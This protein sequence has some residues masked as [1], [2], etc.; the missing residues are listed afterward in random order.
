MFSEYLLQFPWKDTT[1]RIYSKTDEDVRR[2][3]LKRH[4]QWEDFLALIS[5]AADPYL[6]TMARKSRKITEE[7]FGRI[8]NLFLPL[9]L[10]NSCMNSCVYCGFHRQNKM[11]R[12]IL[13]EEEIVREYKAIKELGPFDNILLLTGE[14]PAKAGV[15]YIARAIDLARPYFHNIK[16]EVMPLSVDGYA[17][18]VRHG[19]DG[20]ICFQ[21]TYNREN[22]KIYHPAGMKSNFEWRV[23]A[24]DRM[25]YWK[26]QY[27][28]NFPRMRPAEND[29]FQPNVIMSDR[30]LAQVT[31]AMRIFDPD[32]DISYSTRETPDIRDA[33]ATLGVTTMSA[34][35]CTEPGGY[36][37]YPQALEQ[38]HKADARTPQEIEA[39]LLKLGREPVYKNWDN[40]YSKPSA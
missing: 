30:E 38:F 21:E 18:L 2:A 1:E 3:L 25:T 9:Y 28:V 17:T 15:D 4:L 34:G 12:T 22:Y 19:C 20:V 27:S 35:S 11:K 39:A 23:N 10:T 32:V 6:E 31:F 40:F 16:I 37:C 14:N 26:T 13:T 24:P 7:R 36:C 8:I 33:M 29:G 5:P